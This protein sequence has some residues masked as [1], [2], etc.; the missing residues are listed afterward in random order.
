MEA[1]LNRKHP[2]EG[3]SDDRR[4]QLLERYLRYGAKVPRQKRRG[5]GKRW[6]I[7]MALGGHSQRYK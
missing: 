3:E 4:R 7:K 5:E 2:R 6:K 1:C